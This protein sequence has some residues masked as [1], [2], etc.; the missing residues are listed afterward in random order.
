M[1]KTLFVSLFGFAAFAACG[2][3]LEVETV[4]APEI[5]TQTILLEPTTPT[6][7]TA[8]YDFA[9]SVTTI[10]DATGNGNTMTKS[11]V[12]WGSTG[13]PIGTGGAMSFDGTTDYMY[14]TTAKDVAGIFQWDAFS[15]SM[16]FAHGGG[17]KLDATHYHVLLDKSSK[18]VGAFLGLDPTGISGPVGSLVFQT[19]GVT[20]ACVMRDD[21]KDYM[22]NKWHHLALIKDGTNG[23]LWIDG[24]LKTQT[25]GMACVTN[26][27]NLFFGRRSSTFESVTT[28]VSWKGWM[29][30][31]QIFKRAL[32]PSEVTNLF[33]HNGPFP[34]KTAVDFTTNVVIQGDVAIEGNVSFIGGV[35][36]L[37]PTGDLSS[38]TFTNDLSTVP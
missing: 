13:H 25:S 22:D 20:P 19:F 6:D 3:S 30:E 18:T 1:K 28:V 17:G 26:T 9:A 37:K 21:S 2:A 35:T 32:A 27:S 23:Q 38:G 14:A 4:K 33:V 36:Y 15:L 29:D 12:V 34:L 7:A 31:I 8:Y 16:W 11:G 5:F 10:A 24:E